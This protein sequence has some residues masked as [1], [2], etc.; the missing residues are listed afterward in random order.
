MEGRVEDRS[1]LYDPYVLLQ[2][3]VVSSN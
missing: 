1:T 3:C 2:K